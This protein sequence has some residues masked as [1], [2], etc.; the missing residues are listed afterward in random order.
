MLLSLCCNCENEKPKDQNL[1]PGS[2]SQYVNGLEFSPGKSGSGIYALNEYSHKVIY[3]K[4]NCQKY[5]LMKK[6]V[7]HWSNGE[8][9]PNNFET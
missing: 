4:L 3:K 8:I 5:A 7:M 9:S 2:H 6:Q 1:R